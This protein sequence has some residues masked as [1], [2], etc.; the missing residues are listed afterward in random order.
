M[1]EVFNALLPLALLVALGAALLRLRFFDATFRKQLDRLVYWVALP[2]LLVAVLCD[3]PD[4]GGSAWWMIAA[5]AGATVGLAAVGWATGWALRLPAASKGVFTQAAFRGNLAFVG[6][7]VIALVSGS[8]D[9][10][11]AKAA[12]VLAPTVV[13]YNV[14]GVAVLVAAQQRPDAKLPLRMLKSL[15]TNPLLIAC[16]L[17]LSLQH[18]G[19]AL[20][21]SVVST[22]DLLGRPAAPLA[23][24]SLGGALVSYPVG[25]HFGVAAVSSALKCAGTP[26]LAWV[27]AGWLGLS[28]ADREIVL[29]LAATPTAVASYVLA[30]QLKGDAGLAATTIVLSTLL[31]GLSLGVV[32]ALGS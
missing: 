21:V 2:A 23:L 8:N 19:V 14:L 10:V 3:A 6:L 30:T 24:I 20:P 22:L 4:P 5:M 17:G 12:L 27:I 11:L 15:A 32:L 16:V 1:I 18:F 13:L 25:K 29:I 31:S 7:P 28:A 9:A 26:A